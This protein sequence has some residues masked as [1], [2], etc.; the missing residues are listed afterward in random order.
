MLSNEMEIGIENMVLILI[1]GEMK[2]ILG[3]LSK[4]LTLKYDKPYCNVCKHI[5][6]GSKSHIKRHAN[7]T[8]HIKKLSIL[9]KSRNIQGTIENLPSVKLNVAI[10]EG[11]LKMC[12]F[13]AEHN[14]PFLL[15]EHLPGLIES[16]CPDSSIAKELKCSRT[17]A[18]EIINNRMKSYAAEEISKDLR[19]NYFS[20]IIDE[21]TDISTKKCLVIVVRYYNEV[22][23][24]VR[25]NFLSL[26]ELED[27]S[28]QNIYKDIKNVFARNKIPIYKMIGF[29]SDN[30]SVMVGN[31]NGVK[32]K[33][34]NDVPDLFALGY[35]SHSLHLTAS[36]ACTMLPDYIEKF[37][38][39]VY[40][41]FSHSAKRKKEVE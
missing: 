9:E 25:D 7:T 2:K 1:I 20:I 36:K 41:Y 37:V 23:Q 3:E 5:L 34:L 28:A 16:V 18:T 26:I 11:E 30:A 4:W 10:N 22:Q 40:G 8:N 19:N 14:L 38:K 6:V 27:C 31:M 29:A 21:T 32:T 13:L 35:T 17:K 15:M 24:R 33:L 12:M 39:D